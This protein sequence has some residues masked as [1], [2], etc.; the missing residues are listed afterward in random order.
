MKKSYI[1]L[2]VLCALALA[3]GGTYGGYKYGRIV[4]DQE[5][6]AYYAAEAASENELVITEKDRTDVI[7]VYQLCPLVRIE[8]TDRDKYI[9][10]LKVAKRAENL[11][12]D[13]EKIV[14]PSQHWKDIYGKIAVTA[15]AKSEAVFAGTSVSELNAFARENRGKCIL[16]QSSELAVDESLQIPDNT[17]IR[18]FHT[19]LDADGIANAVDLRRASRVTL[20]GFEICHADNGIYTVG[21]DHLRVYDMDLHD[22]LRRGMVIYGGNNIS[23]TDSSLT[24]NG[25]GGLY[26]VDETSDVLIEGN[27]ISSNNGTGNLHAGIVMTGNVSSSVDDPDA[28]V[29]A[30]VLQDL[31]GKTACPHDIVIRSNMIADNRSSGIY[32]DGSYYIYIVGNRILSNEKEGICMDF[33]TI[34]TFISENEIAANG[35][36]ADQTDEDLRTDFVDGLGRLPDGSSPAKLPGVSLDNAMWNIIASNSV[37]DNAGSGVKSVRTAIGNIIVNNLITDNNAGA[38]EDFHFFGIELGAANDGSEEQQ[39]MSVAMDFVAN[40]ENII[41]RNL[42]YGGHYSGIYIAPDCFINDM[43]ENS[44]IGCSQYSIECFST[45]H[46]ASVNNYSRVPSLG[47]QLADPLYVLPVAGSR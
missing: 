16:V 35:F 34:G 38:S 6:R 36:R 2:A 25:Y 43:F 22:N 23:L 31:S 20:S 39:R 11:G 15:P 42:I 8:G 7:T 45:L 24:D 32:N 12:I 18:G 40:Y 29:Y 41:V 19:R 30:S 26:I 9:S 21:C 28:D 3:A 27:A 33:G 46:N 10:G 4:Q 5:T 37:H 1:A 14:R 17:E 13:Y 47:I 44:I